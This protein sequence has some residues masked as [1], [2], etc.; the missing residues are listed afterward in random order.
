MMQ[1]ET[2]TSFKT[3][4][5]FLQNISYSICF[6]FPICSNILC[7]LKQCKCESLFNLTNLSS[8][9][10]QG[11]VK[12][13]VSSPCSSQWAEIL[14][15]PLHPHT[16]QYCSP[17][18]SSSLQKSLLICSKIQFFSCNSANLLLLLNNKIHIQINMLPFSSL[19]LFFT[20]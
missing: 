10:R 8:K 3:L 20:K 12:G 11:L 1:E 17:T 2:T 19:K 4:F 7:T 5:R 18:Y 14:S 13:T 15:L 16:S 6:L 9:F